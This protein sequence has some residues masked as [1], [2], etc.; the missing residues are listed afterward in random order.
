MPLD[1]RIASVTARIEQRSRETRATYLDRMRRLGEEGP[2]RAHLS[3]GNQAHAYAAMGAD[4]DALVGDRAPNLGVVT[5]YNDMLSAHQPFKD[6]PDRIKDAARRAGATAQVA[7]GVPAMCDGVTQGQTGMELSLFSRDVIA[8]AAGVALSHNTFDAALYLGVCDK[9]VPGLVI[10]AA[11]FGYI[12]GIFVPAGP[13]T[14]GLPN[15]EKS[16]VRQ[17]FASGEIGRAK[18]MEAEMASYHGPGT[19]TFYGTANSNQ[20]LMEFMGL[21]LPGASFVNPGTPLRDA[22]TDA[23][24][25]RAAAITALG[26]DYRPVCDILDEKAFV[27]GMVGLMATGGSTNLVIHLVAMARAAGVV[28]DPADFADI[29]AATPLMARVYPNGLADVNHFHAAGGLGYMIGEL[30]DAGLLHPDTE[31]VAGRGLALYTREPRLDGGALAWAEGAKTTLNDRILRPA[32]DP[33]QPTGGLVELEGNLGRG[34]MKVSAVD[35]ERHVIEAPAAVFEDQGAVKEAFRAGRLDRDVVVVVRFQGPKANGMPE[36]HALTPILAVLQDRG[37]KVALVTDGR[38]SGASGKVPSAIHVAPEALDGGLIGKLA[39]GDVVRVDAVAGRIEV[40]TDGVADRQA[41]V[42]DLSANA[43]GVGRE[44]FEVFR[45]RA[46]PA[47]MG[48]GVVV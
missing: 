47:T 27:N 30:L 26:N 28:L 45:N 37:H 48:A 13:M 5:A 46:G 11:T 8:L 21:H 24:A 3:C 40:L 29:S 20:M 39:D 41:A 17:Q 34:V 33:F 2:R 32:S 16:K 10:A 31:T 1:D 14:S 6:Y 18:L 22:L 7:G 44:L 25:E 36:L 23:A 15:D 4:K 12:P 35:A 38:M 9:I 19:C 42:P 43:W